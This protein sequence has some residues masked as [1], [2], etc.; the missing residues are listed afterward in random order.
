[1]EGDIYIFGDYELHTEPAEREVRVNEAVCQRCRAGVGQDD[2][3][4]RNVFKTCKKCRISCCCRN[5]GRCCAITWCQAEN[6]ICADCAEEGDY[7]CVCDACRECAANAAAEFYKSGKLF[8]ADASEIKCAKCRESNPTIAAAA[9]T[10]KE[11]PKTQNKKK[12]KRTNILSSLII[13]E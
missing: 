7:E 10:D 12:R 9:I 1:M 8:V 6:D 3:G 13:A 11:E 2:R 4:D 5:D